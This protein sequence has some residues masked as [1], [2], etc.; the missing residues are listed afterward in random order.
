MDRFEIFKMKL[1]KILKT[2]QNQLYVGLG[3]VGFN[4][5][6]DSPFKD[7][8]ICFVF[9]GLRKEGNFSWILSQ[10]LFFQIKLFYCAD[11]KFWKY[12]SIHLNGFRF[13]QIKK[14]NNSG[15]KSP[16]EPVTCLGR[17]KEE[18]KR[19]VSN[20]DRKKTKRGSEF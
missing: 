12:G 14:S 17:G 2:F 9:I 15:F 19:T 4:L 13:P 18:T 6:I 16:L 3:I 7:D 5:Q 1:W 10:V 11:R 20:S 8:E